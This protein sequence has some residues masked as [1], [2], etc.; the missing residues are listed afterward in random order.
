MRIF[1]YLGITLLVI[2]LALPFAIKYGAIYG[3]KKF[4]ATQASI[5]SVY[6]NLFTGYLEISGLHVYGEKNQGL[7]FGTLLVD[8]DMKRLFSKQAF[9]ENVRIQDF[10]LDVEQT[11]DNFRIAGIL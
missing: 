8:I 2:I 7:H 1:K 4:G 10:S 6:L 9:L 11:A 3:L 5:D